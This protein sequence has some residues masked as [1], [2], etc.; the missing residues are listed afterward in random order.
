MSLTG[1]QLFR[2]ADFI[3]DRLLLLRRNRQNHV[4]RKLAALVEEMKRLEAIQRRIS[5]AEARQWRA[6]AASCTSHM[7]SACREVG[8]RLQDLQR[9]I[10]RPDTR[11]PSLKDIYQEIRQAVSEFGAL[12]YDPE[13]KVLSVT[14]EPIVLDGLYLGPFEIQLHIP[15]LSEARYNSPYRVEALD[16]HP[17]AANEAVTHPHVSDERLCPGD[18]GASIDAALSQGR[19]CDFFMLV[20]SVLRHYN[21]HSPYVSLDNWEGICCAECGYVVSDDASRWCTSCEETFCSECTR[22]CAVCEEIACLNCLKECPGCEDL[23][24]PACM[25]RCPNCEREICGACLDDR[26][27]PCKEQDED[28]D[29]AERDP[30]GETREASAQGEE[31]SRPKVDGNSGSARP[32]R[33]L[34]SAPD[35]AASR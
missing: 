7:G 26:A 34:N 16:P 31:G 11:V 32:S 27:C 4:Q 12:K 35:Y 5:L 23:V 14:T 6:A 1:K 20:R 9:A 3:R 2:V 33:S 25:S 15:E 8:F 29:R 18:A 13:G 19:V 24:C 22:C 21:P 17:A 28:H 30:E 10:G